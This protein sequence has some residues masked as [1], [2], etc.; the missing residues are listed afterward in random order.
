[1][2]RWMARLLAWWHGPS[3]EKHE[4]K[5]ALTRFDAVVEKYRRQDGYVLVR[6]PK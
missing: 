4:V 1:M 6:R 3:R 2:T 5:Q